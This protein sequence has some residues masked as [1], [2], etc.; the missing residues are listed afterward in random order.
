MEDK[1][2]RIIIGLSTIV[3]IL[4]MIIFV[5]INKIIENLSKI[6]FLG[7]FLFALIYFCVFIL[8]TLRL[9]L[10]FQGLNLE[11]SSYTLFGSFGIGWGVN[12]ITPGKIGDLVRIELIREREPGVGLSKSICGIAI[13][14]VIDILI[15]FSITC[16]ALLFMYLLDVEWNPE[17]NLNFYIGLCAL[18][19]FGGLV[20]LVILFLR[21][22]WIL[23]IIGKISVKLRTLF[24]KFLKNFLE[25]INDF[26]KDPKKVLGVF[27]LSI[28]IWFLETL[29]LII[30]FYLTGN[31]ISVYI[32]II[33]QIITFFTKTFPITPGGWFVSENVGALFIFIFY[34]S[35]P[36]N[37]LLSLTILDHMLRVG[38]IFIYG[39][40]SAL[41]LNFKFR[42]IET[43]ILK[44]N[45][46]QE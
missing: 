2:R 32:I 9:K 43:S 5:D 18:L 14:R 3:L 16:I 35:I 37:N 27:A 15:L 22:E 19:L 12:E 20:V 36:Y 40:L 10:I 8:R 17:L 42:K 34:P 31:V 29:T 6:S 23:N 46:K 1:T 39:I 41:A 28:L 24:E 13:E 25:G 4:I 21:T 7:V 30:V 38:F 11:V 45:D 33:A 26:R 44:D